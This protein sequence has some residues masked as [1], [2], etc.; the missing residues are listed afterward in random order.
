VGGERKDCEDERENPKAAD[1]TADGP[2][3]VTAGET[4]NKMASGCVHAENSS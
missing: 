3:S 4:T 2:T 1:V